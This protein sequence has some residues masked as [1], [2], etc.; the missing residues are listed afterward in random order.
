MAVTEND[1]ALDMWE[2]MK[3]TITGDN[4]EK[5]L[6]CYHILRE[7]DKY[8]VAQLFADV[9]SHVEVDDLG[10]FEVGM[11]SF[12]TAAPKPGETI[13]GYHARLQ[14]LKEGVDRLEFTMSEG[15]KMTIDKSFLTWKLLRAIAAEPQYA[16][17]VSEIR[18]KNKKAILELEPAEILKEIHAM[19][20]RET[21]LVGEKIKPPTQALQ[22]AAREPRREY[23]P[24]Q[25]PQQQQ[26]QHQNERKQQYPRQQ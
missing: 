19:V 12:F 3:E 26:H 1:L 10:S 6:F 8:D 18:R 13:H 16:S 2:W 25:R 20:S 22:A 23:E 24:R 11:E 5:P 15:K 9:C 21:Q 14:T 4:P 17:Y 7:T